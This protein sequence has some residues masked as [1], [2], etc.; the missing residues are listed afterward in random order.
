MKHEESQTQRH[1]VKW[2][3][4][5]FKQPDYVIFAVPNGGKRGKIEA[6]IMKAEGVLA[7]A[8]DLVVLAH[9]RVIFIEM[10]AGKGTQTDKQKEFQKLVENL[11]FEYYISRNFDEFQE[12]INELLTK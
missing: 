8:S 1:C 7:G 2:F 11:G 10:K 6:G 12:L 5:Q 4:Y 9:E 3:R